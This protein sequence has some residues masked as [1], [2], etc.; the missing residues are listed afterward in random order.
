MTPFLEAFMSHVRPFRGVRPRKDIAHLVAAPPYDVLTSEEARELAAG[1]PY[2]FLHIGKP[3]IDLP[4]GTDL[5][6]DAVYAKGKENFER[7]LREGA[8]V[9]DETRT[10]TI[11]KPGASM[12][13]TSIAAGG[14]VDVSQLTYVLGNSTAIL[15]PARYDSPNVS[16]QMGEA[17]T[18]TWTP[19]AGTYV[20]AG[21]VTYY[22]YNASA[23]ATIA[24]NVNNPN[25]IYQGNVTCSGPPAPSPTPR[26]QG[27]SRFRVPRSSW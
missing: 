16:I 17:Q 25:I 10:F 8:I 2:S 9:Q 6:A 1:N 14:R 7:F 26:A 24:N 22:V 12:G 15:A 20:F 5:Y 21:N 18:G 13:I 4:P 23:V 3:E 19:S 11:Y 27:K